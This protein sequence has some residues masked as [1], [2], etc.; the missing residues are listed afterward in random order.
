MLFFFFPSLL[1]NQQLLKENDLLKKKTS[2]LMVEKQDLEQLLVVAC[3]PGTDEGDSSPRCQGNGGEGGVELA[4][5]AAPLVS[6]QKK[7]APLSSTALGNWVLLRY[8]LWWSPSHSCTIC[9][10]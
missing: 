6:R 1:Q 10:C 7:Q 4:G 5:S 2:T 8:V 3:S 9:T